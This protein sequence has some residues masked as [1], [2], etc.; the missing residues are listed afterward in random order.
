[1]SQTMNKLRESTS[2]VIEYKVALE[3]ISQGLSYFDS[4]VDLVLCNTKYLEMLGFP[5][6][7]GASGTPGEAFLRWNA[8]HG[9][10]GEGDVEALVRERLDLIRKFEPHCFERTRLDG[11]IIRVEGTP[12]PEGGFV[13]TY[14]DVTDLRQSQSALTALN[15]VL[16]DRVLERTS[17]L[18]ARE[19]EISAQKEVLD[20][21]LEAVSDGIGLFDSSLRLVFSNARYQ[22]LTGLPNDLVRYG[23]RLEESIRF[24]VERGE[25]GNAPDVEALV[26]EKL[27]WVLAGKEDERTRFRPEGRV[28]KV[29]VREISVGYV[30]TYSDITDQE[31][32]ERSLR[33][34]NAELERR[35]RSRTRELQ[36]ATT[37]AERANAAKSEFL[38]QMSHELRTPLNSVI[39]YSD[40][41]RSALFGPLG[42]RRYNEYCDAIH[43]SGSHLLALI[44]DILEMSRIEAGQLK[45]ILEEFPVAEVVQEA[46][47]LA[48]GGARKPHAPLTVETIDPGLVI[49]AD[50]RCVVQMLINL[51]SNAFKFTPPTGQVKLSTGA[52]PDGR[53]FLEVSDTGPGIPESEVQRA[54]EPFG[55]LLRPGA[56]HEG[57]GLGLTIVQRMMKLHGGTLDILNGRS[58]G[59]RVVLTF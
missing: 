31:T 35:V 41:M 27:A 34:T 7:M 11:R 52:D 49:R 37:A 3:H 17:A 12:T 8:E 13:T 55:Q 20:S 42:D 24:N 19:A 59:T 25:Y 53:L 45:L 9:E 22:E 32:V 36:A 28:L 23:T 2:E 18:R 50:K 26:Q 48:K 58:G 21:L 51:L 33:D 39:G 43:A 1:M 4:N 30:L 54:I 5:D 46:V 38:A 10:Y 44:S 6:W 14:T 15:Q 40:M 57:T 29:S 47:Q 16:E 56:S